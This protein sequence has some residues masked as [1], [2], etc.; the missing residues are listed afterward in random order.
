MIIDDG[1]DLSL[2]I[3]EQYSELLPNIKGISEETTT[4]VQRLI[5][6][7]IENKELQNKNVQKL[8]EKDV[9]N[10]VNT[11]YH[12]KETE[13][14][15]YIKNTL[16]ETLGEEYPKLKVNMLLLEMF[17]NPDLAKKRVITEIIE[18]QNNL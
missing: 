13:L 17:D 7:E 4:G 9:I 10:L 5:Q 8:E 16:K 12:E 2:F 1:G 11:M 15:E 3:H 6:L 18:Y 14:K